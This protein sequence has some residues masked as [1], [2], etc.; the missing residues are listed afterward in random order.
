MEFVLNC[1]IKDVAGSTVINIEMWLQ[2]FPLPVL[3][4]TSHVCPM[5]AVVVPV[6]N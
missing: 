6:L 1:F 3:V 5:Y 2:T 4:F